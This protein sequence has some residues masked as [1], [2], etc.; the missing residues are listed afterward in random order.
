MLETIILFL[1]Q[2]AEGLIDIALDGKDIGTD[3][4]K[5]IQSAYFEVQV[6]LDPIVA[7]TKNTYDDEALKVF[8][9]ACEDLAQE[10]EF[11]LSTSE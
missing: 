5:V 2:Q 8:K 10:G 9:K 1:I 3:G 4:V 11:S 7:D 6:W